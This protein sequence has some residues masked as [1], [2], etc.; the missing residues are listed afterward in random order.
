MKKKL[1]KILLVIC[2]LNVFTSCY[3]MPPGDWIEPMPLHSEQEQT[4]ATPQPDPEE[5]EN[6]T[7]SSELQ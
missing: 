2:G 4:E 6:G 3:G 1:L 7:I 5:A